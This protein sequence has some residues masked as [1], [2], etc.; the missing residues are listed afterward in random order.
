[1]CFA[2]LIFGVGLSYSLGTQ[3]TENNLIQGIINTTVVI[4][5]NFFIISLLEYTTTNIEDH[6]TNTNLQYSLMKKLTFFLFLNLS[7]S[8]LFLFIY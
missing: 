3:D 1:M 2:I 7:M 4:V 8:P 6:E 5:I